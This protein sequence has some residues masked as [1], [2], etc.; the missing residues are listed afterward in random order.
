MSFQE[1]LNYQL[2]GA[3]LPVQALIGDW[4]DDHFSPE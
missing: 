1:N 2:L 3:L 4:R